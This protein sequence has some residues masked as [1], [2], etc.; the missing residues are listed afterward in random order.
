MSALG[1]FVTNVTRP[2]TVAV[3]ACA[4]VR[5]EQLVFERQQSL[6]IRN[7]E[8]EGRLQP[9]L[10]WTTLL[11]RGLLTVIAACLILALWI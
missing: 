8:W 11:M 9:P 4:D 5:H 1:I 10:A 3:S 6:A 2:R 7:L